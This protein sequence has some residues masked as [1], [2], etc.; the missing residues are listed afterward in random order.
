MTIGSPGFTLEIHLSSWLQRVVICMLVNQN[1]F[2]G[3]WRIYI[4][5]LVMIPIFT[6]GHANLQHCYTNL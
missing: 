2:L 3:N 6:C 4:L 5:N 1:Q